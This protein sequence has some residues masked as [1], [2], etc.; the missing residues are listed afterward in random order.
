M[1]SLSFHAGDTSIGS[2]TSGCEM[3]DVSAVAIARQ[4]E[5]SRGTVIIFSTPRKETRVGGVRLSAE[6]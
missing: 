5:V 6:T 2:C 4:D 3:P 1:L